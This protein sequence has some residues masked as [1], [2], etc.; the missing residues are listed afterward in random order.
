MSRRIKSIVFVD[1]K[2]STGLLA[3]ADAGNEGKLAV[4][5][6]KIRSDLARHGGR[7][8]FSAG[9]GVG[10]LFSD[11]HKAAHAAADVIARVAADDSGIAV[12]IG[13][14]SGEVAKIENGYYGLAINVAARLQARAEPNTICA[15]SAAAEPLLAAPEFLLTPLGEV[16]L[17]GLSGKLAIV[18]LERVR[19]KSRAAAAAAIARDR[20]AAELQNG[21][22]VLP[23]ALQ[24]EEERWKYFA[25]G[26]TED[27]TGNLSRFRS[28]TV[29]APHSS[30]AVARDARSLRELSDRLGAAYL[31]QGRIQVIGLQMR[32]SAGLT[33]VARGTQIW[34]DK[35]SRPVEYLFVVLDD[36][37]SQLAARLATSVEQVEKRRVQAVHPE[38]LDS[39]E[40]LLRGLEFYFLHTRPANRQARSCFRR[41]I[42]M[43][44]GFARAYSALSKT[45]NLDW[46]YRWSKDPDRSLAAALEFARLS[47]QMDRMDARGHAE[48]GFAHLYRRELDESL[49]AYEEALELN[50]NDADVIAE[51]ADALTYNGDPETS[52][53]LLD[54]AMRLNPAHPDWYLWCQGGALHQ[55]RRYEEAV[56]TLR[57][58]KD[59][60]EAARLLA[61]SYARLGDAGEAARWKAQVLQKHPN[62]SLDDWAQTQP[63]RDPADLDHFVEG[64][65]QAGLT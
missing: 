63:F 13:L 33:D 48:L 11:L 17:K 4:A 57:K 29:I 14:H 23:F 31:V 62:F 59:V 61:A 16:A 19:R 15:S 1:V 45:Y 30:F 58:M 55:C 2:D 28:L 32:I 25:D 56:A 40:L 24:A 22:A 54:K 46:R 8:F 65:R 26:F 27:L 36:I 43:D 39:Y 44:P 64:L 41:A 35:F 38:S 5:V 7:Q 52:I 6:R 50:P 3:G 47:V 51:Y 20:A 34:S 10:F 18:R 53:A 21:I 42:R 37:S 49:A 60:S 9:D 12:R